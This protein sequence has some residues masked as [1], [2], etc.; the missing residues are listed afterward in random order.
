[1]HQ[2]YITHKNAF[3]RYTAM[4]GFDCTPIISTALSENPKLEKQAAKEQMDALLQWFALVPEVENGRTLQM[5]RSTDRLWHAFI[6]NTRIY[7]D[8][9][10]RFMGFYVDH[11]PIEAK[12]PKAEKREYADYTLRL[13]KK[14]FGEAINPHLTQLKED[15]TCCFF[16]PAGG[17]IQG[18][19]N[20]RVEFHLS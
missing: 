1:M 2:T 13:L 12:N 3:E 14:E 5:L 6:L 20:K 17:C 11:D 18:E 19:E 7:R 9:C 4:K 16:K 10:N 8:F 15:V